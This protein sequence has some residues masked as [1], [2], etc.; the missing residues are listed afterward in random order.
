MFRVGICSS[1]CVVKIKLIFVQYKFL[2]NRLKIKLYLYKNQF[3]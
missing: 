1:F 2:M 3:F